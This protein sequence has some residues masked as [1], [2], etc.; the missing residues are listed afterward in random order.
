MGIEPERV[1]FEYISA[2]EGQKFASVV[3]DFVGEIKKIG[4]SPLKSQ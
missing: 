3:T 4:P 1:K 2:S